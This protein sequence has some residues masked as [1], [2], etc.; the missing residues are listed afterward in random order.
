[1][2]DDGPWEWALRLGAQAE[3]WK[4]DFLYRVAEY[5]EARADFEREVAEAKAEA[6]D[7]WERGLEWEY[8]AGLREYEDGE[9]SECPAPPNFND[10]A[11][12]SAWKREQ[13]KWHSQH[14]AQWERVKR[15]LDAEAYKV[16]AVVKKADRRS[17]WRLFC[18]LLSIPCIPLGI[19]GAVA[20]LSPESPLGVFCMDWILTPASFTALAIGYIFY[21]LVTSSPVMWIAAAFGVVSVSYTH[22]TL[23]TIYSV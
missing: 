23:P 5:S 16:A 6:K 15:L 11:A 20:Y 2:L 10:T 14:R 1:M 9:R 4:R 21:S 12:F 3:A 13:D 7:T 19:A 18:V 22:L 17:L 8:E